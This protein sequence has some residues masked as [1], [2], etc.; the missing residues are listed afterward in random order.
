MDSESWV[1]LGP[2]SGQIMVKCSVTSSGVLE[3]RRGS[4]RTGLGGE[5]SRAVSPRAVLTR[6][7][8]MALWASG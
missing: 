1:S 4:E 8:Q 6:L 3:Q 7:W 2:G 5:R